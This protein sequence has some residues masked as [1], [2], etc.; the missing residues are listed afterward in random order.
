VSSID[1][2]TQYEPY[3]VLTVGSNVFTNMRALIAINGSAPL[4]VGKGPIP[5]VWLSIP[6]NKEGTAWYPLVKDNF[7]SHPGVF[8]EQRKGGV[9]LRTAQGVVVSATSQGHDS[10]LV[11]ALDLRPFGLD[12]YVDEVGLRVMGNTL[13]KNTFDGVEVGIGVGKK[14]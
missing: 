4:L 9:V 6:A 11:D 3:R 8:V 7:A 13:T 14:P 12:V 2:P 5:R 10:V 1:Y